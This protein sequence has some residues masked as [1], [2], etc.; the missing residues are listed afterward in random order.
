MR[1]CAVCVQCVQCVQCVCS[2]PSCV[3]IVDCTR[4]GGCTHLR[5]PGPQDT[6][7]KLRALGPALRGDMLDVC[8]GLGYTSIAAAREAR[9]TSVTTIE[10]D[11]L[12][13]RTH[14]HIYVCM[15]MHMCMYMCV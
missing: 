2:V 14:T 1:V 7:A 8:T 13:A 11:P 3:R 6:E 4:L 12:M 5:R 15:H 9:V 10:L